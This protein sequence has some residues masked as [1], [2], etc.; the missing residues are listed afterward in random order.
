MDEI[1]DS[2]VVGQNYENDVRVILF[3]K[4]SDGVDLTEELKNKIKRNIRDNTSPRHVP[5][6]IL[7][8]QEVPVTLNGK[9]VEIAVRNV[10]EGKP[11]TNKD[12]LANPLALDQFVNIPELKA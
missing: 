7:L 6:F 12:A 10:L 4:P 11:V 8:V 2:I 1:A 3:V 5:A 9:K